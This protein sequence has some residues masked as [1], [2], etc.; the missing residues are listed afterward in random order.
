MKAY[1][2]HLFQYYKK[3]PHYGPL[4]PCLHSVYEKSPS[5]GDEITYYY[6]LTSEGILQLSFT[7]RGSILTQATAALLVDICYGKPCNAAQAISIHDLFHA[8]QI[9]SAS[10]GPRA[11]AMVEF[12]YTHFFTGLAHVCSINKHF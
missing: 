8:M 9:D 7:G 11:Y 5:C 6:A 10:L 1:P 3:P 2:P 4:R 12:A